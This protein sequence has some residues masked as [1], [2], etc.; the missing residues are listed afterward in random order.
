[1]KEK[2]GQSKLLYKGYQFK[3]C[4]VEM[5]EFHVDDHEYLQH[6]AKKKIPRFWWNGQCSGAT[7]RKAHYCFWSG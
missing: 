6:Y 2:L 1:M 3:C 4:G 7:S 5:I